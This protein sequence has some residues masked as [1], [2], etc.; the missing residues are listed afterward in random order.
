[1]LDSSGAVVP[2]A[3]VTLANTETSLRQHALTDS[4]GLYV[5]VNVLPGKYRLEVSKAGFK[6]I[7]QSEFTLQVNQTATFNFTLQV[8][9][10]TEMISVEAQ[11]PLLQSSTAEGG[12]TGG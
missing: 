9:T 4:A 3:H 11:A 7:D 6:T 1:V 5:L 12:A 10:T 8:G 2:E